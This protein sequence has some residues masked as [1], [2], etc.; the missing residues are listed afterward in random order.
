MSHE[1]S[2]T[3]EKD[4]RWINVYG[5][6]TPKAG[7]RLP[8][9]LDFGSVDEAVV[10]AKS[11]SSDFSTSRDLALGFPDDDMAA[12]PTLN[13]APETDKSGDDLFPR[14]G[15]AKE[16]PTPKA[17][18]EPKD[19]KRSYRKE[20]LES[21][22]KQERTGLMLRDIGNALQGLP[23][24]TDKL[25]DDFRKEKHERILE[26]SKGVDAMVKGAKL[27]RGLPQERQAEAARL[28]SESMPEA[29]RSFFQHL[30]TKGTTE[31]IVALG[32]KRVFAMMQQL[33]GDPD[34][35]REYML[36]KSKV[37][38][39]LRT[40]DEQD[41]PKIRAKLDAMQKMPG[42]EAW[43]AKPR[44]TFDD[45][46]REA[47]T[48]K[49]PRYRLTDDELSTLERNDK[50]ILPAYGIFTSD[51]LAKRLEEGPK[52]VVEDRRAAIQLD[53]AAGKDIP[54]AD[55]EFLDE[56]NKADPRVQMRREMRRETDKGG[57]APKAAKKLSKDEA[58]AKLL[59][60][61]PGIT[62]DDKEIVEALRKAGY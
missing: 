21:L 11:R 10:A 34:K 25:A 59:K 31:E 2:E 19:I 50:K 49:D 56:L 53:I 26:S 9:S 8:D 47:Q 18:M 41:I 35:A 15:S 46:R 3:I 4:G 33:A 40:L 5:R 1:Q 22:S 55:R 58:T 38:Q 44:K 61:N 16:L 29:N 51:M 30:V 13:L 20:F 45:L 37:E 24:V 6:N 28:F 39:V 14:T 60:D 52:K 7:E 54:D 42:F 57:T 23:S 36:D 12:T 32:D 17:L 27:V 43:R 62:K 48:V